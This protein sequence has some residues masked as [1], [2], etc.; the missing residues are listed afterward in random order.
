MGKTAEEKCKYK[1]EVDTHSTAHTTAHDAQTSAGGLWN[2]TMTK[3]LLITN[4]HLPRNNARSACSAPQDERELADLGQSCGHNPLDVLAG[5]R[6]EERQDQC[7]QNKLQEGPR[8][9]A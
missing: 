8:V 2:R 4:T 5:F 1:W 3:H 9:T 6:Q 7:C